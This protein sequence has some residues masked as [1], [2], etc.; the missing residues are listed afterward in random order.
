MRI[1]FKHR[2][3]GIFERHTGCSDS[4][5][6]IWNTEDPDS[7]PGSGR[8]PGE[9]NGFLPGES[10]EQRSLEGYSP[11]GHKV[12]NMTKQLSM[13]VNIQTIARFFS[14]VNTTLFLKFS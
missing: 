14:T 5:E 8:S 7:V 2:N 11:W 3:F 10:H 6:S 12:S 9:G 1:G 4:K 13:Q